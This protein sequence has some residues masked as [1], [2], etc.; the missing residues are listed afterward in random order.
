MM[1]G[2]RGRVGHISPAILDTSA[3]ECRKL[4]PAGVLHVGLSISLP[5]Q[6][7]APEELDQAGPLMGKRSAPSI[8]GPAASLPSRPPR[9]TTAA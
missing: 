4:L 7:M 1:Y 5:V 3:E 6:R 9:A 2:W 8:E